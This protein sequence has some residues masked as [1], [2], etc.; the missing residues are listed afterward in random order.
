[1]AFWHAHTPT[2][3]CLAARGTASRGPCWPPA[4]RL[5]PVG[6]DVIAV[7]VLEGLDCRGPVP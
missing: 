5:S 2:C 7:A 3:V 4:A 1:M 6:A